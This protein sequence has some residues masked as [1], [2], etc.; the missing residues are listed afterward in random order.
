MSR[1]NALSR[2]NRNGAVGDFAAFAPKRLS[3]DEAMDRAIAKRHAEVDAQERGETIPV[4]RTSKSLLDLGRYSLI[5]YVLNSD[6]VSTDC[7]AIGMEKQAIP[8]HTPNYFP[9]TALYGVMDKE[10]GRPL[11]L[12][13][14]MGNGPGAPPEINHV[15]KAADATMP[16]DVMAAVLN[17]LDIPP[18]RHSDHA[19]SN[20]FDMQYDRETGTWGYHAP[21]Q[22]VVVTF[23]RTCFQTVPS[24]REVVDVFLPV[25]PDQDINDPDENKSYWAKDYYRDSAWEPFHKLGDKPLR[26]GFS[27]WSPKGEPRLVKIV[28]AQMRDRVLALM[29]ETNDEDDTPVSAPGMR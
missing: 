9:F 24:M 26:P 19:L 11:A 27:S 22:V 4:P 1:S 28:D 21:L 29:A 7:E 5:R 12:I 2:T 8:F 6:E 13:E 14:V 10:A 15:H 20:R 18:N 16:T 17:H 25:D 3:M 23:E